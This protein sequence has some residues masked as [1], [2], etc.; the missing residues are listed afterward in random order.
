MVEGEGVVRGQDTGRTSGVCTVGVRVGPR[1]VATR[2]PI[3][4]KGHRSPPGD[5]ENPQV[6]FSGRVSSEGK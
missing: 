2:R 6:K 5:T 1:D 4:E 3:P